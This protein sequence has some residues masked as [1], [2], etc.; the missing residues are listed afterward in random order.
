MRYEAAGFTPACGIMT[1]VGVHLPRLLQSR[2]A[3]P[4]VAV[5]FGVP[6]GA[7]QVGGRLVKT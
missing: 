5:G 1:V 2:G 7:A 6:A 4:A 3:A